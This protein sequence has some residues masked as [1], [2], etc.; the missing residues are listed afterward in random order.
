V[1]CIDVAVANYSLAHTKFNAACFSFRLLATAAEHRV[2]KSTRVTKCAIKSKPAT[3]RRSSTTVKIR[4]NKPG[5]RNKRRQPSTV[6]NLERRAPNVMKIFELYKGLENKN[7]NMD[8]TIS[9]VQ[10]AVKDLRVLLSSEDGNSDASVVNEVI[11]AGMVPLLVELLDWPQLT[12]EASWILTN[13]ASTEKTRV[14]AESGAVEKLIPLLNINE[15]N[16]REQ[17]AWCIGNV[18]GHSKE[19]REALLSI[20]E[21]VSAM[22]GNLEMPSTPNLLKNV[23][24]AVSNLCRG[25]HHAQ[26]IQPFLVAL[27]NNLHR[28][29]D[30]SVDEDPRIDILWAL[31]HIAKGGEDRVIALVNAGA[32]PYLVRIVERH[33][34]NKKMLIPTLQCIRSIVAAENSNAIDSVI[35]S[36]FLQHAL[37]LLNCGSVSHKM[38]LLLNGY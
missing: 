29:E 20:P 11:E 10:E 1:L 19:Y 9:S 36:G 4:K 6:N 32:I 23:A 34:H 14:V 30:L 28:C 8:E 21:L 18:A 3:A 2:T 38:S 31:S 27:V 17:A 7:S 12:F 5:Q 35:A 33:V 26:I 22:I 16:I 13:I 37:L 15:P 24:W 25:N